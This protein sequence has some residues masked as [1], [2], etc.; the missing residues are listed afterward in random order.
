MENQTPKISTEN[1]EAISYQTEE[2]L[3]TVL[4]GIKLEGLDR[5]RVTLK[6]EVVNREFKHYLNNPEL[7]DLAIR[8][9]I[10]L[11]NDTQVEKLI[12]K[13]LPNSLT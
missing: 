3:F 7:A 6:I 5:L 11:Y 9:N 12:R 2:L 4:G 10:D 8:H 13:M 1:P